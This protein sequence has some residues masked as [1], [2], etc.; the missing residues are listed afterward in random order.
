MVTNGKALLK[1]YAKVGNKSHIS[2]PCRF[3]FEIA[4]ALG[5]AKIK[6][7]DFILT[8]LSFVVTFHKLRLHSANP[9]LKSVILF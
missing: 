6:I 1:Q 4:P 9:K 3:F 2:K 7:C 5:K 8:L